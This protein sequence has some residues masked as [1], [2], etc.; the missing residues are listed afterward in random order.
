[1]KS[2]DSNFVQEMLKNTIEDQYVKLVDEF[3]EEDKN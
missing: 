3:I 1:M 2:E